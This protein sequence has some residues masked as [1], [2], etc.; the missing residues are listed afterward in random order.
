MGISYAPIDYYEEKP[1]YYDPLQL[2]LKP[3][4]LPQMDSTE[5]NYIVM[6]FV[7]GVFAI[8][9]SDAMKS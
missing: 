6:F 7:I 4:P 9:L 5:C 8:A 1:L 2:R 3:P